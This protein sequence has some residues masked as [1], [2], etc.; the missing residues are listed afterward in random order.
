M[1]V[2]SQSFKV[3]HSSS[4]LESCI[5]LSTL[6]KSCLQRAKSYRVVS[7]KVVYKVVSRLQ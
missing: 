2:C 6:E 4:R 3:V 7:G 1:H 5:E